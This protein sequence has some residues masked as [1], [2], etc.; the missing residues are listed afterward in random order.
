[1]RHL[2]GKTYLDPEQRASAGL[3]PYPTDWTAILRKGSSG[4]VAGPTISPTSSHDAASGRAALD[5]VPLRDAI[6]W[7]ALGSGCTDPECAK[8]HA[9]H[10]G[11]HVCGRHATTI[12]GLWGRRQRPPCPGQC[13]KAHPTAD[14]LEAAL[15]AALPKGSR[16]HAHMNFPPR[17]G[18]DSSLG[19]SRSLYVASPSKVPPPEVDKELASRAPMALR[20]AIDVGFDHIMSE[21]ERKSLATQCGLCHGIASEAESRPH[22]RSY[23]QRS[24]CVPFH[25]LAC[26]YFRTHLERRELTWLFGLHRSRWPFAVALLAR[27]TM[28]KMSE[29]CYS[30]WRKR[31][32]RM[33]RR[34]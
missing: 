9:I 33:A 23:S 15:G 1:M 19:A 29:E 20:V 31:L 6:C 21:G 17:F 3:K 14:E 5:L 2:D 28:W 25:H 8:L 26:P 30:R 18:C 4:D 7:S 22:V 27:Q 32:L 16:L 24:H 11:A 34:R 12:L 10:G 13:G